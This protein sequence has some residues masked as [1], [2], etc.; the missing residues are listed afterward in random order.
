[1]VMVATSVT[2][3]ASIDGKYSNQFTA[4]KSSAF[5]KPFMPAGN[6]QATILAEVCSSPSSTVT[7]DP[8]LNRQFLVENEDFLDV[9]FNSFQ[10][11]DNGVTQFQ[12]KGLYVRLITQ[13]KYDTPIWACLSDTM[14]TIPERG[15]M[16]LVGR[17][18]DE[19][20]IPEIQQVIEAKGSRTIMPS[21]YTLNTTKGDTRS[22][23]YGDSYRVSL[24]NSAAT[25]DNI[26]HAEG[27]LTDAY[28]R[29]VGPSSFSFDDV[30]VSAS[31]SLNVNHTNT[32]YS[33]TANGPLPTDKDLHQM[34]A[35]DA[36]QNIGSWDDY[37][38]I[39]SS[40]SYKKTYSKNVSMKDTESVSIEHGN[41]STTS[42]SFGKTYNN[43]TNYG[44]SEN[45]TTHTGLQRSTSQLNRTENITTQS[46]VSNITATGASNTQDVTGVSTSTTA[47]GVSTSVTVN[48]VTNA[49][50]L[51]G[52]TSTLDIAAITNNISR[53]GPG[54]RVDDSSS[55]PSAGL[56]SFSSK[57]LL[58]I[59]C[60][61]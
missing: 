21:G 10:S 17:S 60:F 29:S 48:G 27:I 1:M 9:E 42:T 14:T 19:T 36:N 46:A 52:I 3:K 18:S 22:A 11:I 12:P 24:S 34:L 53:A 49:I 44:E 23:S 25:T 13:T 20:E 57:I 32:S 8:V 56:E 50:N 4:V 2:H 15:A 61:L 58:G 33:F 41:S 39:T 59:K 5:A 26:N 28:N 30:S 47:S 37:C 38:Q 55:R 16:V 40:I 7:T 43:T 6:N 31:S 45:I 51:T 54:F 35:E